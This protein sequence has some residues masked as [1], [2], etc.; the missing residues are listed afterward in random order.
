MTKLNQIIAVVNGE[1][2][3]AQKAL[4]EAHRKVQKDVLISG[5]SRSY[6]PKDEEGEKLPSESKLVNY[7][8][9]DSLTDLERC[10]TR[11]WDLVLTQDHANTQTLGKIIVDGVIVV[12]GVPVTHLLF[13]EKQLVDIKTFIEKLPTLATDEVWKFSDEANAY[14]TDVHKTLRTKKVLKNHVKARATKEHPEQVD[15][16]TEDVA[17]GEWDTVK[18]S[19]AIPERE[20]QQLLERVHKLQDAVKQAREDAN[21]FE[22]TNRV[23]GKQ[24]FDYLFNG[25]AQ[26]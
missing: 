18:F 1:K 20:K 23:I 9:K 15:V 22:I 8:V 2:Q 26:S 6:R 7:T 4:T 21:A 16:Y 3:R 5:I 25:T 12:G 13:I 24:M 11:L 14:S 19:G 17:V 10:L